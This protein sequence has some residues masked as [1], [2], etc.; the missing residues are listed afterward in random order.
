MRIH[1][2]CTFGDLWTLI[3]LAVICRLDKV[4]FKRYKCL[5]ELEE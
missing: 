1:S 4:E 3:K 5:I 2:I